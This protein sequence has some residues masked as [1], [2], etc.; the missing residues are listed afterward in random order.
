MYPRVLVDENLIEKLLPAERRIVIRE[1]NDTIIH[2]SDPIINETGANRDHVHALMSEWQVAMNHHSDD[3]VKLKYLWL[4]DYYYWT[5]S[6]NPNWDANAF[7][8]FHSG[9]TRGFAELK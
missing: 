5:I 4:L 6:T 3:K 2:F 9:M 7:R 1:N 8:V